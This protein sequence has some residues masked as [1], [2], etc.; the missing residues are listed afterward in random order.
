MTL[1]QP[2]IL[3]ARVP[4]PVEQ[5]ALQDEM[6]T[7]NP[8]LFVS[9][10][11]YFDER[12]FFIS[13]GEYGSILCVAYTTSPYDNNLYYAETQRIDAM[14]RLNLR[15]FLKNGRLYKNQQLL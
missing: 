7:N 4:I 8:D 6:A 2:S 15:Y 1:R 13:K 9:P 12:A 10:F 11:I 3:Y 14:T 5:H